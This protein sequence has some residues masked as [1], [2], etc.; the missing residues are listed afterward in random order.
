MI[1]PISGSAWVSSVEVVP[2][3]GGMTVIHNEQN[4]LIPTRTDIGWRMSFDYRKLN[5]ATL[6]DHYA[7][8]FVDQL[9][10]RL[11]DKAYHYFLDG[12]SG[13]NQIVVNPKDQEKTTFT[14]PFG[15]FACRKMSF[16]LCNAP[17]NFPKVYVCYFC[18]YDREMH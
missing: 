3:K 15:V 17:N 13:Y 7:L 12:Y 18:I 4:K 1:Y 14:C 5:Q 16:W 8:L 9:L 2:R 6:K 11:E 10:E